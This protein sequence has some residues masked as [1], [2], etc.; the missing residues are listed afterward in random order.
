MSAPDQAADLTGGRQTTVPNAT[1]A[2]GA[3]APPATPG[4]APAATVPSIP[5][6]DP[7]WAG[8]IAAGQCPPPPPAAAP[9]ADRSRYRVSLD[10]DPETGIVDGVSSI[11]FTPDLMVGRVVVRLWA[12][13]PRPA[14]V[15]TRL[16]V[17]SAT[18][19]GAPVVGRLLDATTLE[20]P[21][22]GG[23]LAG[24]EIEI[25]LSWQ[26]VVAGEVRDRVSRSAGS[27]RLGSALP[28]IPWEPGRGWA[29][30]PPTSG[31]A[32]SVSAPT[33]DWAMS[34]RVPDGYDVLATGRPDGQGTW[35]APAVRDVGISV[36]RFDSR[37]AI[38]AQA[39]GPDVTVTVGVHDTVGENPD[40]YLAR[41][42]QSLAD[43]AQRFGPYPWSDYTL[44]ITPGLRG[45][46]EFPGHVQQ[47]PG[48]SGRTTPHEV[49]HQWF[50]ALVGNNQGRD[51]W[52]DEGLA[53]YA[54]GHI[55]G[56]INDFVWRDIPA[57]GRGRAGQ[58]MTFW[59]TNLGAYYRSV[60]V[61]TAAGLT[62]LG[63]TWLVDC[64]LRHHAAVNAHSIAD[65]D[66]FFAAVEPILPD[67][68][69]V[70]SEVGIE[71]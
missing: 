68:R 37:S 51:P 69:E 65:P 46:I 6:P 62:R 43:F 31:F 21:L 53:T 20:L 34:I 29:L 61:Q 42:T 58:P 64:A 47:G 36:G 4:G 63:P 66:D 16:E 7:S 10:I 2:P 35:N 56:T 9:R 14:S 15:G 8:L 17:R 54:E 55:E 12:N 70:L 22:D 60:Y 19:D 26:L 40:V 41:V 52:M 23:R 57:P 39:D 18:L 32:E 27:L 59:E 5:N 67:A 1:P 25:E 48:S 28:I 49:G 44:A 11:R 24:T 71:S 38:V 33:A 30:E 50:Y 45:G 3:S 13:A